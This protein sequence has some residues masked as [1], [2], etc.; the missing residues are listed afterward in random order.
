[1]VGDRLRDA[2]AGLAA[3]CR[4][5]LLRTGWGE[6]EAAQAR[7][8]LPQVPVLPD[9]PAACAHILAQHS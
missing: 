9:L 4:A 1:M 6:H 3:G 2:Q 5:V 7:A 8:V